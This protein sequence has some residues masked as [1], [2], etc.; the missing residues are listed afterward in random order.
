MSYARAKINR[1]NENPAPGGPSKSDTPRSHIPKINRS[2]GQSYGTSRSPEGRG[3]FE[4][5]KSVDNNLGTT[6][7]Y[8][9]KAN[10]LTPLTENSLASDNQIMMDL[11]GCDTL[12]STFSTRQD[13]IVS[14]SS[15]SGI[16]MPT[17]TSKSAKINRKPRS[18]S[19]NSGRPSPTRN[20]NEYQFLAKKKRLEL[21]KK[22]LESKQK[23]ILD[24]YNGLIELKKKIESNGV[25]VPLETVKLIDFGG[26][27]SPPRPPTPPPPPPPEENSFGTME[28][29]DEQIAIA[30]ERNSEYLRILEEEL[31][32]VP[33]TFSEL[34]KYLMSTREKLIDQLTKVKNG[35]IDKEEL[36]LESFEHET[37]QLNGLINDAI[38]RQEIR[39]KRILTDAQN[40]TENNN[41]VAANQ[42]IKHL[43]AKLKETNESLV[44]VS[45]ELERTQQQLDDVRIGSLQELAE[46]NDSLKEKIKCLEAELQNK[47]KKINDHTQASKNYDQKVDN[48][49]KQIQDLDKGK[50]E[51]ENKIND[52][53]LAIRNLQTKM[54]NTEQKWREEK[55]EILKNHRGEHAILE[56]LS[57][58]R[59]ALDT[60]VHLMNTILDEQKRTNDE[61][62]IKHKKEMAALKEKLQ[63]ATI[64]K[65][66]LEE[67]LE[68]MKRDLEQLSVEQ[69]QAI[70]L[71]K[72]SKAE[73]QEK[74]IIDD[75]CTT[76][77]EA[78]LRSELAAMKMALKAAQE[79]I[80]NYTTEK[81]RFID[82]IERLN[83]DGNC[84]QEAFGQALV[85]KEE[86]LQCLERE[87]IEALKV[88][89]QQKMQISQLLA[90]VENFQAGVV[91]NHLDTVPRDTQELKAMLE[92]GKAKLQ[93]ALAKSLDNEQKLIK[94]EHDINQHKKQLNDME[95]LLKVRDGLIGMLKAKKDELMLENESLHKYSEEVRQ[96]LFDT[97]EELKQK[98]DIIN[99]LSGNLD[100]KGRLCV[101]LEKKVKDLESTLSDTNAKRFKLQESVG[102]MEK[103][104]QT[105][106]AHINQI[107]DMQTRYDLDMTGTK[108]DSLLDGE[109]SVYD[110]FDDNDDDETDSIVTASSRGQYRH[111]DGDQSRDYLDG[112]EENCERYSKIPRYRS[113]SPLHEDDSRRT[114]LVNRAN[115]DCSRFL[116]EQ[117]LQLHS[118][119][120]RQMYYYVK[121]PQS[122]F[123][124][125]A[126]YLGKVSPYSPIY[127]YY[128]QLLNRNTINNNPESSTINSTSIRN[129]QSNLTS[130]HQINKINHPITHPIINHSINRPINHP[131][132]N[133]NQVSDNNLTFLVY[134]KSDSN[135]SSNVSNSSFKE[136]PY[137]ICCDILEEENRNT[138]SNANLEPQQRNS[139][140]SKE[141][142][143][144]DFIE[145][146]GRLC[147]YDKRGLGLGKEF[148]PILFGGVSRYKILERGSLMWCRPSQE[149]HI[150]NMLITNDIQ[151]Q[152][153]AA[154]IES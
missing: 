66:I 67:K 2:Y 55:E 14:K 40:L 28:L 97:K 38:E 99:D 96:L 19:V 46:E 57:S 80:Q 34:G 128:Y 119:N 21:L 37:K 22:D 137:K 115:G 90:K 16:P 26:V 85:Q 74:R 59:H 81:M 98:C 1:F 133:N 153:A 50:K 145:I 83:V 124:S 152:G 110:D 76:E 127:R 111:D 150:N 82:N 35:E 30:A 69:Q 15:S 60:R 148:Q 144:K 125:Y 41:L 3:K 102:S 23:P 106:K 51:A 134:P 24:L 86:E 146:V 29:T 116:T 143:R 65:Q 42:I 71:M 53:S 68:N 36:N 61:E 20:T 31:D 56:K 131:R 70:D 154:S 5:S 101:K 73:N 10:S 12:K 130:Y 138:V 45:E 6:S 136:D 100:S 8:E 17:I 95:N 139:S 9:M 113:L 126:N 141:K 92:E 112:Y 151:A 87:K 54:K 89:E 63:S 48:L 129:Y 64:E 149:M 135:L 140:D 104:L 78:K 120:L 84:N 105:T 32:P 27:L 47:K 123:Q 118:K 93:R 94:Y 39:V 13:S 7:D 117:N 62:Q 108:V 44:E 142:E 77:R 52:M 58:E 91:I 147:K 18:L 49:N 33:I 75:S 25:V 107:A 121:M 72:N 11:E 43:D 132:S 109:G 122:N 4:Q 103:E 114:A 88:I 79:R